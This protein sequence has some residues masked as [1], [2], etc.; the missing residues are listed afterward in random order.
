MKKIT[1]LW[2][3]S[4]AVMA[5]VACEPVENREEMKG[6]TTMD[7]I[8]QYVK[9]EQEIRDGKKSNFFS[10]SSDHLDALSSFSYGI[11]TYA[12]TNTNGYIQCFVVSG[13]QEIVFTALN[14]DGTKL[15]KTF[16]VTIDECFDVAPEWELLCGEGSKVWTWDTSA[17]AYYGNGGYLVHTVP[18]WWMVSSFA[19]QGG[20]H[21][22][23]EG[24]GAT[25]TF[26]ATGAKFTKNKTD[27]STESGTFSFDMS[28]TK[29][30]SDGNALWSIGQLTTSQI[31]VLNGWNG[32]DNDDNGKAVYVYDILLLTDTEMVLGN[33]ITGAEAWD[34]CIYWVFRAE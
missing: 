11:G 13:D 25:M 18:T 32:N 23:G 9:V 7:K 12:G 10:L 14:A 22:D 6:A 4:V 5:F 21:Y 34:T 17:P 15:T 29:I 28:K 24:E 16:P 30:N 26:S 33:P 31:V 3:I 20:L 2:V 27:G 8:N 1:G 19:D